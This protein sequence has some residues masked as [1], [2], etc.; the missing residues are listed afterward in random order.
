MYKNANGFAEENWEG[1]YVEM[2]TEEVAF[3]EKYGSE[4]FVV[5]NGMKE[6]DPEFED[7][8]AER[9]FERIQRLTLTQRQLRL[10][11]L[12][13][14]KLTDAMI[15]AAL[16][17]NDAALIEWE[18]ASVFVRFNPLF[19]EVAKQIGKTPKDVDEMFETAAEIYG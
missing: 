7:K 16:Q 15:R 4:G 5:I 1:L 10:Y 6:I 13:Q 9:E 17:G 19:D 14:W 8:Q 2:T 3:Y 11:L 18:Y 12:Q